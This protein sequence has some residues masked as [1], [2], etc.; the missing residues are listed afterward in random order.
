MKKR[1][2]YLAGVYSR[3]AA[4]FLRIQ[5]K[6]MNEDKSKDHSYTIL[7]FEDAINIV[8]EY[9]SRITIVNKEKYAEILNYLD[10][11]E[12]LMNETEI[13]VVEAFFFKEIEAENFGVSDTSIDEE[14]KITV[15][16]RVDDRESL[17]VKEQP[18]LSDALEK[19]CYSNIENNK[20]DRICYVIF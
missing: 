15:E 8:E 17:Q 19:V 6:R 5:I 20:T 7:Q 2:V 13:S 4:D 11:T 14:T 1:I 9:D 3:R 12:E 16:V 18:V 10:D